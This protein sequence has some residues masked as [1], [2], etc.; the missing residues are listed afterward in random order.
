MPKPKAP[1]STLSGLIGSDSEDSQF[2]ESKQLPIQNTALENKAP[3]KKPRGR[4]KAATTK[5]TKTKATAPRASAPANT[6]GNE[7]EPVVEKKSKRQALADRTNQQHGSDADEVDDLGGREDVA[8]ND[9]EPEDDIAAAKETESKT[10]KGKSRAKR[11]KAV[12]EVEPATEVHA[13][14]APKPRSRAGREKLVAAPEIH[15][16]PSEENII[17][18]TETPTMDVDMD[19][20][21]D[22]DVEADEEVE[23]VVSKT[24]HNSMRSRADSQVK[25]PSLKRRRAGSASDTERG[26]PGVRRKL[27]EMTKKYD[28]L[29]IRYQ[30]LREIGIKEAERNFERLRKDTDEERKSTPISLFLNGSY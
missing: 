29:H 28:S 3:A 15:D 7:S 19:E 8:M 4:P 6:K 1:R 20:D 18:E 2:A 26:D 27:G 17:R 13:L 11:E 21:A 23:D 5:A 30:D 25:Q 10:T 9:G 22:A 24:A 14:T 12:K 16:E